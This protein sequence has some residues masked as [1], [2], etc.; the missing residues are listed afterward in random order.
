[1]LFIGFTIY[2]EK[3]FPSVPRYHAFQLVYFSYEQPQTGH[4]ETLNV[5]VPP[6]ITYEISSSRN[7]RWRFVI[8]KDLVF[9]SRKKR[10]ARGPYIHLLKTYSSY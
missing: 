9:P 4:A 1:M 2:Q 7:V 6:D 10:L 8:Y 3:S 5:C